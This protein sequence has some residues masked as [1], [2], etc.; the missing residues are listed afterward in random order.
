[1]S[2]KVARSWTLF[3]GVGTARGNV[4]HDAGVVRSA[5]VIE[6]RAIPVAFPA[7]RAL[8]T[9]DDIDI[10]VWPRRGAARENVPDCI[11]YG[12]R[13]DKRFGRAKLFDELK[14]SQKPG[15]RPYD[16]SQLNCARLLSF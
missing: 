1:M 5:R 7:T 15:G 9:G 11:A 4:R 13:G 10:T 6:R 14:K 2:S 16:V 3:N 8:R 12:A